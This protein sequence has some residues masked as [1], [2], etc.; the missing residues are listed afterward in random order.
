MR[1]GIDAVMYAVTSFF[2]WKTIS[3]TLIVNLSINTIVYKLCLL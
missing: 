3:T 2:S 1:D